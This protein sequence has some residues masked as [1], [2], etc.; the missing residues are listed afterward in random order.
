MTVPAILSDFQH[1]LE[2][3][4]TSLTLSILANRLA[5]RLDHLEGAIDEAFIL[6]SLLTLE[7]YEVRRPHLDRVRRHLHAYGVEL[8]PVRTVTGRDVVL[9][10]HRQQAANTNANTGTGTEVAS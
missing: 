7:Q 5:A 9:Y 10:V 4:P 3:N 1:L 6:F 2:S 8:M